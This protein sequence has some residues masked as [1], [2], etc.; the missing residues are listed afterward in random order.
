MVKALCLSI[1]V[2]LSTVLF[3]SCKSVPFDPAT[4]KLHYISFGNGGGFSGAVSAFFL[5]QDG[6]IFKEE[7]GS[8]MKIK[9][10]GKNIADQSFSNIVILGLDNKSLN[11]PGNRYYFIEFKK[12][13][14]TNRL[15]WSGEADRKEN[16][17]LMYDMLNS[18]IE[19]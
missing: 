9:S 4:S 17:F 13:N 5:T 15:V 16:H 12:D 3:S 7:K 18:L 14:Q 2:F 11:T 19:K 10:V 8:F 1:V 6:S